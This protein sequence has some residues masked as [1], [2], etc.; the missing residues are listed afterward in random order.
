MDNPTL[1][2]LVL[3]LHLLATFYMLGLI[4]FVQRVHYPL[5]GAVG[6][7]RFVAY[8]RAHVDR[9]GSVVVAPM[10]LELATGIALVAL[11]PDRVPHA[12]VTLGLWLLGLIWLSTFALQVPR[13]RELSNGFDANAHARLVTTNWIRTLAWSARGVLVAW[14]AARTM[15]P[16]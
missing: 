16:G 11:A 10:L 2:S 7:D 3:V 13:H 4:W 9:T 5:F 15:L 8:E 6:S 1:S 12:A 14:M